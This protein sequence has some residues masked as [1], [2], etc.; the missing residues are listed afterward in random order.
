MCHVFRECELAGGQ[1]K[2]ARAIVPSEAWKTNKI[3]KNKHIMIIISQSYQ[4]R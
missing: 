4:E 2:L 1:E 3:K